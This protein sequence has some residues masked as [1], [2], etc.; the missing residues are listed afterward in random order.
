M[1][2][3]NNSIII[4]NL[5]LL[6][7]AIF[8][9]ISI[10]PN[11]L[12]NFRVDNWKR[13]IAVVLAILIG[14]TIIS[15]IIGR[16]IDFSPSDEE[17]EEIYYGRRIIGDSDFKLINQ[18][19]HG[20]FYPVIVPVG[21]FLYGKDNSAQSISVLFS[22]ISVIMALLAIRVITDKWWPLLPGAI[23]LL[24]NP[25]WQRALFIAMGYPA[26]SSF[27]F[28][29][30]IL[31]ASLSIRDKQAFNLIG[32]ASFAGIAALTKIE[33]AILTLVAI[34]I[35]AI[36]LKKI[37]LK[38]LIIPSVIIFFAVL[39][40]LASI[41]I[42]K[43][44]DHFCGFETQDGVVSDSINKMIELPIIRS[45]EE[46]VKLIGGWRFSLAYLIDDLPTII[47]YW[48]RPETIILSFVAVTGIIFF[49]MKMNRSG[50][51]A[52]ASFLI[53]TAVYAADCATYVPRFAAPH[54]T[55]VVI[56]AVGALYYVSTIYEENKK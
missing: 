12:L 20:P 43:S 24:F 31:F 40:S 7:A 3:S 41:N 46:S 52:S 5:C 35:A 37:D 53:I 48:F 33:Y 16:R 1:L 45:L 47:K 32:L 38:K 18:M 49:I 23:L 21:D 42:Q 56:A 50:L 8:S 25:I 10:V 39:P 28:T 19:R 22:I 34:V 30:F 29:G 2:L 26:I 15:G 17:W 13:K 55:F 14:T 36:D 11:K 9:M 54:I 4:I 6:T 27:A 44:A 51:A